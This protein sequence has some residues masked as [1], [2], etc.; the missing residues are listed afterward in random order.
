MPRFRRVRQVPPKIAT[1]RPTPPLP[2][3][4][5]TRNE[6]IQLTE[7]QVINTKTINETRFQYFR[8]RQN[9]TGD[10][11]ILNVQVNDEF[12]FG[13]NFPLQYLNQDNYELQN[14]TS[15]THGA[16]FIKFGTRLREGTEASYYTTNF[17]GQYI[18]D[19]LAAYQAGTPTQ[20]IVAG[21]NPSQSVKQ[22]D[23]ALFVQDDWK[24][25]PS[26]T[27]SLG[28]RYEIQQNIS[29]YGD[30]A[31]RIGLAWGIGPGQ[32]R[33]RQPKTVLRA[34]YGWFYYRLPI[35]DTLQADRKCTASINYNI[36]CENP[37][38]P[39][40]RS[41]RARRCQVLIVRVRRRPS[42]LN[43]YKVDSDLRAGL[44]MQS[45]IGFD[46]Q[47]PKNTTL[48]MN[49]INSRGVH[50]FQTVNIN[51]P[52]PLP[53]TNVPAYSPANPSAATY[54]YSNYIVPGT[55]STLGTGVLDFI[56][57]RAACTS[58]IS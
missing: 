32:G 39:S 4:Q 51:T 44:L 53:G 28:G 36:S 13:S 16:H 27:L 35:A 50:S 1:R 8:Q 31:P 30:F 46:R 56:R 12:A 2:T 45:A 11:P 23:A 38:F 29:D 54:P 42:S 7:T 20:Y 10:N 49:Y 33:L 24:V 52:L 17:T 41:H 43:I 18:F 58:R 34:G 9:Q 3:H 37:C 55:T 15:S 47:L 22:F 14:Y 6:T 21:G 26:L 19:S 40:G 57:I 5:V 48:S 25:K